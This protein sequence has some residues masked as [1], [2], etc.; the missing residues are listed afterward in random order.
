MFYRISVFLELIILLITTGGL[1]QHSD[2]PITDEVESVRAYTR[3]IEFDYISWSLDAMMAKL[4]AASINLPASLDKQ[5][6]KQIVLGYFQTTNMVMDTE[7]RLEQIYSDPNIKNKLTAS[8]SLHAD[9]GNLKNRQSKLAPLAE[10]VI[11]EQVAEVLDEF[12]L[13]N[14][15]QAI[16]SVL[17]HASP[18]PKALIVSR[19]EKIEQVAN[20]SVDSSLT[21]DE[22]SVLEQNVDHDLDVSSLVVGIGGIGVYPTMILT[23]T[24]TPWLLETVAHEWTHNYLTLRPLGLLYDATPEL[25]T[26][27]ETAASIAGTEISKIVQ[28]R[29]YSENTE[30][31]S[32]N[33]YLIA[34][35]GDFSDPETV[36]PEFDFRAE[37][38][39]TRVQTDK[40][41]AEGKIDEAETYMESRRQIFI[42]HGYVL[43]KLNQAYFAFYGAYADVPGGAAGEDP[44]GPAV[45]ELRA[46]SR[47]LKEFLD[48][49]SWMTSFEELQSSI[50]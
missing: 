47:T 20:I 44:V 46:Q 41:L 13:T 24:D 28:D 21:I 36:L 10:A 8:A 42:D 29:Y 25:R 15:G 19:R 11:Q 34:W 14:L 31:I 1:L 12:E 22:Q 26:M 39:K 37:M 35:Q 9:L 23:T 45:R 32:S 7:R 43:R 49:I 38:H 17:Y 27:N 4:M 2:P 16:P 3:Q 6:Q 40:L 30:F 5:S 50:H 48:K 33:E 18:V